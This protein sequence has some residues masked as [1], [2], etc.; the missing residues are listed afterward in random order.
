MYERNRKGERHSGIHVSFLLLSSV[1]DGDRRL[2]ELNEVKLK[3]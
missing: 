2:N 3:T 1:N